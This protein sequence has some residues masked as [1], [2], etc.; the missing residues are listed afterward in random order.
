MTSK[1]R[2]DNFIKAYASLFHLDEKMIR[3]EVEVIGI[4]HFFENMSLL[5]EEQKISSRA[6]LELTKLVPL[7]ELDESR[8]ISSCEDVALLLHDMN[9]SAT[10]EST[11]VLYLDTKNKVID[12]KIS[13]IGTQE[14]AL[15]NIQDIFKGALEVSASKIIMG[16]N[17]PSGNIT[18]SDGDIQVTK[19]LIEAGRLL[20]IPFVDHVIINGRSPHHFYSFKRDSQINFEGD[21]GFNLYEPRDQFD[22]FKEDIQKALDNNMKDFIMALMSIETNV[23]DQEILSQVYEY[24]M[25]ADHITG[26]INEEIYNRILE[27]EREVDVEKDYPI[28]LK[29]TLI[30]WFN[31][32]YAETYDIALFD[33]HFPNKKEIGMAFSKTPNGE[34][35]IQT[36]LSLDDFM[37]ETLVDGQVV[38]HTDLREGTMERSY[39]RLE[40]HIRSWEFDELVYVDA[41]DL[42]KIGL[43]LD[44]DGNFIPL[45]KGKE[46]ELH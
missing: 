39:E 41:M 22:R 35:S 40:A 36:N 38:S 13:T 12:R 31:Q 29:E 46:I 7:M 17:H 37:I 43:S 20:N 25:E 45:N 27:Q 6:I 19:K 28:S 11:I 44:D 14:A 18:P 4:S 24:Y 21:V 32:N 10:K 30:N 16:H 26:I 23:N 42:A 33:E 5:T 9:V 15:I 34:A 8:P 1:E 3:E 2:K